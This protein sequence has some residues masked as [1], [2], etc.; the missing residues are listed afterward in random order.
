M[1]GTV[2]FSVDTIFLYR[3]QKWSLACLLTFSLSRS[4]L[5]FVVKDFSRYGADE[6]IHHY[7][8]L[9]SIPADDYHI[10]ETE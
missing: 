8:H 6:G 2:L 5:V 10:A 9:L 1:S 4:S 3:Y 7:Y